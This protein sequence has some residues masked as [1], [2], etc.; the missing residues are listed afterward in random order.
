MKCYAVELADAAL[1]AITAQA[2]FIAIDQ[3]QPSNAQLWLGQLWD[4]VDSLEQFPSRCA[5]AE[6]NEYVEYTVR[7]VQ[8]GGQALLFTIDEERH[9]VWVLAL[10][11]QDQEPKRERMPR[12]QAT[13]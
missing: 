10:R 5:L 1:V 8:V 11:G 4:A 13:P 9:C 7:V 2:R 6:E 12:D 3:R